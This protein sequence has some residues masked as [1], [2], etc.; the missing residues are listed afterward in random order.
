MRISHTTIAKLY[1]LAMLHVHG[2]NA[3]VKQKYGCRVAELTEEQANEIIK[4][5]DHTRSPTDIPGGEEG[6]S[7]SDRA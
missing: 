3:R 5:Y 2:F 6:T 1:N 4:A 7:E